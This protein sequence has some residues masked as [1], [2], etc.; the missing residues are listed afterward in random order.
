MGYLWNGG[1]K[2]FDVEPAEHRIQITTAVQRNYRVPIRRC[3]ASQTSASSAPPTFMP[4]LRDHR[5][6]DSPID[7]GIMMV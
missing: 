5:F 1:H 4:A 6:D 2:S 7:S 3:R